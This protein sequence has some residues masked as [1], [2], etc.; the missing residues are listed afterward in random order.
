MSVVVNDFREAKNVVVVEHG[1]GDH[2][3]ID[4]PKSIAVVHQCLVTKRRDR[5]SFLLV[6]WHNPS[7]E[8]LIDD[9][10]SVNLP[11]IGIRTSI[12]YTSQQRQSVSETG[13]ALTSRT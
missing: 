7:K 1:S 8:E 10:T 6:T 13:K 2:R 12:L 4:G 3:G 9:E 11:G 5:Q